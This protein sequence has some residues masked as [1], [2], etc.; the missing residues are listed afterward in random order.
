MKSYVLIGIYLL[1]FSTLVHAESLYVSEVEIT[2]RQ[3][4]GNDKRIVT[5]LQTG[6]RVEIL[7][8][9]KIWS[10]IRLSG[11]KTGWMLTR[12][13][14]KE[15]P[16]VLGATEHEDVLT[17]LETLRGENENLKTENEA[18]LVKARKDAQRL[19]AE[20]AKEKSRALTLEKEIR[21]FEKDQ[22]MYWF[23]SGGAVFLGG[24]L[25]GSLGKRR[26]RRSYL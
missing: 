4:P 6:Q 21:G 9:G 12:Y 13:I 24:F 23:L 17:Q 18:L 14:T 7:E 8:Q 1:F 2:L 22:K 11:G 25:I 5:M 16:K 26:S 10:H 3:G 19:S 15:K 20:L